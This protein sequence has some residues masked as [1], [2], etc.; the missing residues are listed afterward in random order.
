MGVG[1]DRRREPVAISAGHEIVARRHR[2]DIGAIPQLS[3]QVAYR[4]FVTAKLDRRFWFA[5]LPRSERF[6]PSHERIAQFNWCVTATRWI[7][8]RPGAEQQ[9][10]RAEDPVHLR[11]RPAEPRQPAARS[12]A[13][14]A[15]QAVPRRE[16]CREGPADPRQLSRRRRGRSRAR[17]G[18][19]QRECITR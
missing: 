14:P 4:H 6:D 2:H 13:Q 12:A 18:V 7:E 15:Q 19:W 11:L 16:P 8:P 5:V 3:A 9:E 10:P 1:D 17:A